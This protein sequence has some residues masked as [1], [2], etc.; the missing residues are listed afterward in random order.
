MKKIIV[1]IACLGCLSGLG[2]ATVFISNFDSS[3]YLFN[4]NLNGLDGWTLTGASLPDVAFISSSPFPPPVSGGRAIHF[5]FQEIDATSAVLSRNFGVGLVGNTLGYTEFQAAFFV[6]DSIPT[7]PNRDSFSFT[8]RGASNENLLTVSL[9]PTLQTPDPDL[10]PNRVDQFSWTSDYATG[11]PNI[12]NLTEGQWSTINV[13]FTPSGV[14]DV[15]FSVKFQNVEFASGILAGAAGE[16]LENYGFVW[17]PEDPL[18]VGSNIFIIDDVRMIPEPTSALLAGLGAL[19]FA[20]RR[21]R[22]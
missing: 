21:R 13:L 18:D 4:S 1:S 9:S 19:G 14:N 6:V 22:A 5:G 11:N 20:F 7:F 15:A 10:A 8:F 17:D 12:G 3:P 2:Q 16:T